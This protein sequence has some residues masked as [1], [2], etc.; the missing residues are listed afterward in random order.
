MLPSNCRINSFT[1]VLTLTL[2][3]SFCVCMTSKMYREKAALIGLL[4][5]WRCVQRVAEP[6]QACLKMVS[7]KRPHSSD[8]PSKF[9]IQSQHSLHQLMAIN[10]PFRILSRC[11]LCCTGYYDRPQPLWLL[12]LEAWKVHMSC[13]VKRKPTLDLKDLV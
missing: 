3:D 11:K 12:S 5:W 9:S 2:K 13:T 6:L 1:L 10:L 8:S 7:L 4:A